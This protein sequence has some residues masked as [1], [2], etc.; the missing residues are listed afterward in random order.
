[1]S[2]SMIITP[3]DHAV[4][5][6][7]EVYWQNC[8]KLILLPI[9]SGLPP[10]AASTCASRPSG[11]SLSEIPKV[12]RSNIEAI[13]SVPI[14][15]GVSNPT[16]WV[17]LQ[18]CLPRKTCLYNNKSLT[19]AGHNWNTHT[20]RCPV[21]SCCPGDCITMLESLMYSVVLRAKRCFMC[22]AFAFRYLGCSS[23][24]RSTAL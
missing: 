2:S 5:V 22:R 11:C 17:V 8:S 20:G 21:A 4:D 14:T 15:T 1:M 7:V 12:N 9:F 6:G 23:I 24:E 10:S 16:S 13:H 18:N 3:G 19:L